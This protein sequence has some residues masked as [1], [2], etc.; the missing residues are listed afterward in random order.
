MAKSVEKP[1]GAIALDSRLTEEAGCSDDST[2]AKPILKKK[3]TNRKRRHGEWIVSQARPL[4]WGRGWLPRL[5]DAM[6][7]QPRMGFLIISFHCTER[8]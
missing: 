3:K 1:D 4:A 8:K 6:G 2:T 7:N 5:I